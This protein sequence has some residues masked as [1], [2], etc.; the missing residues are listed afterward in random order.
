[1]FRIIL[2][3]EEKLFKCTQCECTFQT[4]ESRDRHAYSHGYCKKWIEHPLDRNV[5]CKICGFKFAKYAD[6]N[7][8]ISRIHTDRVIP[9]LSEGV[10]SGTSAPSNVKTYV[11]KK[12]PPLSKPLIQT[13]IKVEPSEVIRAMNGNKPDSHGSNIKTYVRK[14]QPFKTVIKS[15]PLESLEPIISIKEEPL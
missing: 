9:N 12:V 5:Q 1:M 14:K 15:E 11:R 3:S 13:L 7:R 2:L 6:L 4:K 10:S 8:H